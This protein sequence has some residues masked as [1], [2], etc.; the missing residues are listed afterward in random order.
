MLILRIISPSLS[1]RTPVNSWQVGSVFPIHEPGT[2]VP[3]FSRLLQVIY[4]HKN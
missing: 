4:W 2:S 3:G 1:P